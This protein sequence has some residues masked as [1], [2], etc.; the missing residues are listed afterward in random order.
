MTLGKAQE[1]KILAATGTLQY[2]L[3]DNVIS[4]VE[5]RWDQSADGSPMFGGVGYGPPTK[6]YEMMVA[7]NVIYKF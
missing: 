4:R 2:D 3:W 5:V 6:N 7:A 1:A